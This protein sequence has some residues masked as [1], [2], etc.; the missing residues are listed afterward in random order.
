MTS[1]LAVIERGISWMVS[2]RL[3]QKFSESRAGQTINTLA[4]NKE[5]NRVRIHT[6]VLFTRLV[7]K[8]FPRK[9]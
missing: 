3:L 5:L 4:E 7:F 8:I 9:H 1:P 2:P 6:D